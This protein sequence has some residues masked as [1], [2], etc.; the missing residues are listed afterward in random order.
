MGFRENL[1]QKIHI[2]RLAEQVRRSLNSPE[3]IDRDAMRTLLDMSDYQHRQERDLDLFLR[4]S[5]DAENQSIL[6]L[7][8][9][10]KLYRTT[11]DD[12]VLRK[13]PTIKE[14]VSIRN[15]IKILNDTDV[16]VSRKDET[17]RHLQADLINALDLTYT[18]EDIE[19]MA[20]DGREALKNKYAEGVIETMTLFSELLQ[21]KEAPRSLQL[22]HHHVWGAVIKQEGAEIRMNPIVLFS[23]MHLALKMIKQPVS[24]LDRQ[25]LALLQQVGRGEA[26]AD[27]EGPE[28]WSALK[29]W[30]LA[31]YKLSS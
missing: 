30:V 31:D 9:E 19:A 6:V 20:K 26:K 29:E 27:L 16:V 22:P 18:P 17:L 13:S 25:A 1:V 2:N 7:D 3:R 5:D 10:L 11:I 21:L 15:A 24:T 12:V 14:M 23:L 8:N 4:S 28:V